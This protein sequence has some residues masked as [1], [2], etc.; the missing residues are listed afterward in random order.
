MARFFKIPIHYQDDRKIYTLSGTTRIDTPQVNDN[1]YRTSSDST[2]FIVQTHGATAA[3]NTRINWIF[4]KCQNVD[5]YTLSVP[6]TKGSGTGVMD[7]AIPTTVNTFEGTMTPTTVN[8][9]QHDLY[10]LGTGVLDCIEAELVITGTS[11][12]I[13]EIMLLE[14]LLYFP[15]QESFNFIQHSQEHNSFLRTSISGQNHRNKESCIQT[16]MAK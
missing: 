12:V 5:S 16:K 4:L 13:Y 1:D 11:P 14:E 2:T 10:D 8:G 9:I 6:A 3:T 7:R 15:P